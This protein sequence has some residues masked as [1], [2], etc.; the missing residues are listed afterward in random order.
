MSNI[1]QATQLPVIEERLREVKE[2]VDMAVND[3]MSLVCSEDTVV[4]VKAARAELNK[5]FAA[6]EAQRKAVEAAVMAPVEQFRAV[7]R[8]CVSDAF[9]RADAEL[10]RKIGDVEGEMKARCEA[11]LRDYFAELCE[12]YHIDFL[13]YERAGVVVSMADAKAKTQPPKKLRQQL[14]SFVDRVEQDVSLIVE[15]ENAEEILTEYKRCLDAT[16]AIGIVM[17]RH[18]RM[19]EERAAMAA[20]EAAKA[21]QAEVIKKVE[22][23]APPVVAPAATA[24]PKVVRVTFTVTDTKERLRMLKQFLESNGYKYE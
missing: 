2:R 6:L 10:K 9:K 23:F 8:E 4:T 21:Q 15:M 19:E 1:I 3:A 17:D 11:G 14:L 13:S 12:A 16:A 22:S 18:R 7:Y 5:Q 24:P 20:R